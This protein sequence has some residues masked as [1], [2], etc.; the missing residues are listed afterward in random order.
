MED[1]Y[2]ASKGA[3][4]VPHRHDYYTILL[5][6]EADGRHVLDYNNYNLGP[7]QLH[8]VKPGQVHQIVLNRTP[9][10]YVITFSRE[11]LAVNNISETHISDL[12]L[13]KA[14]SD[15]RPLN[16]DVESTSR[17][18]SVVE[19]MQQIINAKMLNG[20]AGLAALLQL[21]FVY[22]SNEP[23]IDPEQMDEENTAICMLRDF[24]QLVESHYKDWHKVQNYSG[25]LHITPKHLSTTVKKQTGQTAKAL[26]QDRILLE[27]KRL[28]LFTELSIKEVAYGLGFSEPFH[29]SS[30]FKK[31]EGLSPK[32]FRERKGLR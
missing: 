10:G 3:S 17:L 24:K 21:F 32:T 27:A 15:A 1:I 25:H 4:D 29:F 11:F 20:D 23:T 6:L 12:S 14:F 26:I 30:F 16:L 5:I 9:S 13:F 19:Q 31:Q 7:R 18:V 28:L 22:C 8:F 2:R